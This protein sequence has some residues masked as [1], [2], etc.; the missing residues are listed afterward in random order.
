MKTSFQEARA[1]SRVSKWV[2]IH[3]QGAIVADGLVTG[4]RECIHAAHTSFVPDPRSTIER[5]AERNELSFYRGQRS[6][7]DT[8]VSIPEGDVEL[9]GAR[10]QDVIVFMLGG[11]T[12]EE[13][14][15]VALLNQRLAND[16]AGGP[17][18]TRILLG[19]ST[20]H[21]ST[22]RVFSLAA[23]LC[24]DSRLTAFCKWSNPPQ[25]TSHHQYTVPPFPHP[26][27]QP[28]RTPSPLPRPC[29]ASTSRAGGYELSVGGAAGSGLYRAN[30]NEVGASFQ[31]PPQAQYVA[32]GIRDGAGRLWGNVRQRYEE[33]VSRSATPQGQ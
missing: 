27:S 12:Y 28:H 6:C 9:I 2:G 16:A 4:C 15:A 18:G 7:T 1:P 25:N 29:R 5:Q 24:A 14:R 30:P 17:G 11:T 26:R 8:E 3:L 10:P 33:R 19:S 13:S 20:V 22:R 31:V 21:N 32:E 23:C